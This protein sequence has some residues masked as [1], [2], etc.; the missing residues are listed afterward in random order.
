MSKTQLQRR[1][2]ENEVVFRKYNESLIKWASKYDDLAK[3]SEKHPDGLGENIQLDFYCECA[4]ENCRERFKISPLTYKKIHRSR[5]TF[6]I[7]PGHEV[8]SIEKVSAVSPRT[9]IVE[10][11]EV[12][13]SSASELNETPVDNT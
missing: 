11:F 12:P 3:Q 8:E 1:M 13:D 6:I 2:A 5:D 9:A 7:K 4:D 10:K